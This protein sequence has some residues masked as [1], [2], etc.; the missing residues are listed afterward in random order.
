MFGFACTESEVYEKNSFMPAPIYFAHKILKVLSDKR[1]AGQLFD[2]QPDAK[3]QVTVKYVDG[4][5]VGCT[6]VVVSTQHNAKSRNGKKY[7]PGM[8]K[9]M[10]ADAV[11]SRAAERLDAEAAVRLPGQPDRQFRDRRT[12]RRLRPHRPQ[13]HR[14][15]LWRLRP[16]RRRRLLRQ[17]PDQGRPLGRLCRA[18]SRQ[19][20]GRRRHRRTLHHPG[21]L[22]DRRR[23][24]DVG[25]GRYPRHR[26]GRREEA[27][28]GSARA[29]PPHARPTS[30]APS[31]STGRSTG[32]PPPMAISAARP[33]KTAASPGRRPTSPRRS[34]AR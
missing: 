7:T 31:S 34:R 1:R 26:Q 18:L 10:I 9:D 6:K 14:R 16:A 17:G 27:R 32:A 11:E 22:C 12:G 8:V 13:D 3:S 28:K 21:C 5:P 15:H 20:R 25:A 24:S 2:L 23:R 4:K 29:V 33:T 30:A 19:E